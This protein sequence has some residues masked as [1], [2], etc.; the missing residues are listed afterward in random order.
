[1][2]PWTQVGEA[3]FLLYVDSLTEV[4]GNCGDATVFA[5]LR[6]SNWACGL[7]WPTGAEGSHGKPAA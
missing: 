7:A 1:M 6:S 4:I 2:N 5:V 3:A